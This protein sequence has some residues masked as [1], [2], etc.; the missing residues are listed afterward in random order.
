MARRVKQDL[1]PPRSAA[2]DPPDGFGTLWMLDAIEV[3]RV[4]LD[5]GL[6]LRT[7]RRLLSGG[8]ARSRSTAAALVAALTSRGHVVPARDVAKRHA[9]TC[10]EGAGP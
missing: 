5:A 4:A 6:D 1:A 3:Q 9:P 2:P 8:R 10:G 7:V